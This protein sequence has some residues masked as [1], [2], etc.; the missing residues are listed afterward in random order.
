MKLRWKSA[1]YSGRE[2]F[3]FDFLQPTGAGTKS[4]AVPSV[5]SSFRWTAQQVAKVG[6]KQPLYIVANDSHFP[7]NEVMCLLTLLYTVL[8][9]KFYCGRA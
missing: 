2:D 9:E 6:S 1:C 8:C 4:I 3:P 7:K 5:S